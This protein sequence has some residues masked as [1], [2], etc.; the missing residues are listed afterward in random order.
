MSQRWTAEQLRAYAKRGAGAQAAVNA[1]IDLN[2]RVDQRMAIAAGERHRRKMNR[3]ESAY[4][5]YIEL[6]RLAGVWQWWAYEPLKLR[7]ASG[8]YYKPDFALV[9]LTG[10]LVLHE[11]KGFWREAARVRIKVAAELYPH[12]R[13]VAV[14]RQRAKAGGNW[15]FKQ[16]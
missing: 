1:V 13:F 9:D 16:Y 8:A 15:M 11:T 6:E 3:L 2:H 12:F 7:L 5:Q 4:A 14:T 10:R